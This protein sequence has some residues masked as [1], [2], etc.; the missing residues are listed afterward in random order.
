MTKTLLVAASLT[1]FSA[2]AFAQGNSPYNTS[3]AQAG[4]PRGGQERMMG[5]TGGRP[6][7]ASRGGRPMMM[8][9]SRSRMMMHH[10]RHRM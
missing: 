4:G 9:R 8:R 6:E 3:G 10:R 2:V 1:L 5:A 7:M